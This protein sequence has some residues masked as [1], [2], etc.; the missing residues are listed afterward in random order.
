MCMCKCAAVE[1]ELSSLVLFIRSPKTAHL[2]NKLAA[3]VCEECQCVI[4]QSM[5]MYIKRRENI[6]WTD[7]VR[8]IMVGYYW[9]YWRGRVANF[10]EFNSKFIAQTRERTKCLRRADSK[11]CALQC[12]FNA[13]FFS[14]NFRSDACVCVAVNAQV[15]AYSSR[16]LF[17]F[18]SNLLYW[19]L[20]NVLR[21]FDLC[22]IAHMCTMWQNKN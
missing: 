13:L 7:R 9:H 1:L 2:F 19:T 22:Y 3:C 16:T 15:H 12:A 18:F 11:I 21:A 5:A 4:S 6:L 10:I 20:E 14:C 8:I 17:V